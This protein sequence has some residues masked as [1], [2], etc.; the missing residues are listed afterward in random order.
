MPGLSHR[1]AG[2]FNFKSRKL[3]KGVGWGRMTP[4]KSEAQGGAREKK[5]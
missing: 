5:Q 3:H 4:K 2:E 1:G